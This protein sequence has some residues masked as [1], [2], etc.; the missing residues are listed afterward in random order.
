MGITMTNQK[1][2]SIG[3]EL[4]LT[5]M[6]LAT[7]GF[8]GCRTPYAWEG[9]LEFERRVIKGD[10]AEVEAMLSG[11]PRRVNAG[12]WNRGKLNPA[13]TPLI[14]AIQFHQTDVVKL[15]IE[16]GAKVNAKDEFGDIPLHYAALSANVEVVELLIAKGT[17]VNAK[18]YWR[19]TPLHNAAKTGSKDVIDLLLK[20]G[21]KVNVKN[22]YNVT[23]L[24]IAEDFRQQAL[25]EKK[26]DSARSYGEV[27][28]LL[29][30]HGAKE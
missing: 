4:V 29:R 26:M 16:K 1:K 20:N 17:N 30:K 6:Y 21:A 25:R 13:R 23:P 15:L 22:I 28:E 12:A 10:L 5:C 8:S 2:C 18:G 11:N 24:G 3:V 9:D 19:Y 27:A 14:D 7:V